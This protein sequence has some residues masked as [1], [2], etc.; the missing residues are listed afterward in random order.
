MNT[1]FH[2]NGIAKESSHCIY[3]SMI[4][5]NFQIYFDDSDE[6]TSDE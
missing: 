6:E 4:N 2:D 3:L 5:N 1:N